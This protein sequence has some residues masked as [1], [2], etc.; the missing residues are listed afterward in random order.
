MQ[1]ID[2]KGAKYLLREIPYTQWLKIGRMMIPKGIH[3][4]RI[5]SLEE[6]EWTIHPTAKTLV[7]MRFENLEHWLRES[8]GD[9][10][11]ADGIKKII[12]KDIPY[13]EQSKEVY[14]LVQKKIKRL[15][16]ITDNK[17]VHYV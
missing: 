14:E 4:A 16:S 11:L 12:T 9:Y 5:S 1:F 6:L 7:I 15:R 17:E 3:Q 13:V 10:Y 8:I 2:Q